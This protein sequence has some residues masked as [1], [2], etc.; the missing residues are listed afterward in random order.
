M[1][2][3]AV[4]MPVLDLFVRCLSE[5]LDRHLEVQGLASKRV[6]W[7]DAGRIPSRATPSL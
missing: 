6:I 1:T 2:A 7:I 4:R 5:R 3:G